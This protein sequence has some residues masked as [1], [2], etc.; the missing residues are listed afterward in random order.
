MAINRVDYPG[1]LID[2]TDW[3][4]IKDLVETRYL[5]ASAQKIEVVSGAVERGSIFQIGAVVYRTDSDETITGTAS[6]YVRIVPAGATATAEYATDLS[7]VNWNSLYNG[8]YDASG[9]LYVFNE[10]KALAEGAITGSVVRQKY[11][12][13]TREGDASIGRDAVVRRN[14]DVSGNVNSVGDVSIGGEL[15]SSSGDLQVTSGVNVQGSLKR[16][17][18][19]VALDKNVAGYFDGGSTFFTSSATVFRGIIIDTSTGSIDYLFVGSNT[20]YTVDSGKFAIG[21]V[22]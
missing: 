19:S 15:K 14:L 8:Y 2:Q 7:G 3:T 6:D 10:G 21:K 4:E 9:N 5:D 1:D 16:N 18:D 20:N 22:V 17:S 11:I 12:S 13:Q